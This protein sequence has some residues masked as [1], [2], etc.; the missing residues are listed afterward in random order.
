MYFD[1]LQALLFMEGHGA[2][3]WF[4][5]LVTVLVIAAVLIAPV[6]RRK[7]LLARLN[8]ELGQTQTSSRGSKA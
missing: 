6:R 1:S 8:A 5:Y 4:V 7:R 2:Y 3:V